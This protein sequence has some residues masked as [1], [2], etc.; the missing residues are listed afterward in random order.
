MPQANIL[1]SAVAD[2]A[3]IW[4]YIALDSPDNTDLF[5]DRIFRICQQG[6]AS[7]PRLGRTREELSPGLRSLVF[8]SYV[9]FYHPMPNGVAVVRVLHGM[10]DIESIFDS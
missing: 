9:I 8:E 3:D 4:A 7:N 1:N 10:R 2:L 6:L 5:I